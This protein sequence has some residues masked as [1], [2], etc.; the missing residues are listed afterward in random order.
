MWIHQSP[1]Q[2]PVIF[3]DKVCSFQWAV[4]YYWVWCCLLRS[5][6][7]YWVNDPYFLV[8]LSKTITVEKTYCLSCHC[9][10]TNATTHIYRYTH[11]HNVWGPVLANTHANT[12]TQT[13][14]ILRVSSHLLLEHAQIHH[15][16]HT[17]YPFSGQ[18]ISC[19]YANTH[20]FWGP[21]LICID[22]STDKKRSE[23]QSLL[24]YIQIHTYSHTQTAF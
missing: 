12:H 13:L 18:V 24:T 15:K 9:C 8:S 19:T 16:N 23:D 11:T 21:I 20:T 5:W 14:S 1:Q 22:A 10:W 4:L 17:L 7:L 6:A 2:W 3:G